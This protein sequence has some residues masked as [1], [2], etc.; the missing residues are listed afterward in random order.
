MGSPAFNV[1]VVL[2]WCAT[3][4]WLVAAKIV[5]PLRVGE[6]PNYTSIVVENADQP[7]VCWRIQ[8]Q[9]RTIGWAAS[10]IER[11][12]DG[13]TDLFSRVYL[14][15]LPWDE[16]APGWLASVL[17]PV[18]SDLGPLDIDKKSHLVIDPLRRPVEFESKV[19]VANLP[20]AIR[21]HGQIEGST[22]RLAV[23]S[24]E[25][26]H[27]VERSLPSNALVTDELSP[28]AMMPGLRVGQTWTVPL[29]SPFRPF[30]D[31]ME[32]L[33]AVVEREDK[34]TWRGQPVA[35]RVIIYRSDPGSGLAGKQTRGRVWVR[36]D[37]LVLR[38]E[39]GILNSHLQFIRLDD[40]Q[41]KTIWRALGE[42]WNGVLARPL[43]KRLLLQLEAESP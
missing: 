21:V 16:F 24:G 10:K 22:L 28:H 6:P 12:K 4:S 7:P 35:C 5:P 33:E 36:T 37:G 30:N 18:L 42:D 41:A 14:G 20:D 17:K 9:D 11:R 1:V 34:I 23:Q 15:E 27:T 13:I 2:F 8:L 31:P 3:M 25:F 40:E 43:A 19:R 29:Y 39:V 32:M 26:S 38:Q